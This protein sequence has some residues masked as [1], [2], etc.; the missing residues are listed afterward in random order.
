[1]DRVRERLRSTLP[2]LLLLGLAFAFIAGCV[3]ESRVECRKSPPFSHKRH[4]KDEEMACTDCHKYDAAAG[5]YAM[6][7]FK[8]CLQCH[9]DNEKKLHLDDFLVD[10]KPVWSHVTEI[11]GDVKFSHKPHAEAKVE[12]ASCHKGIE[13][14]KG[15]SSLLRVDMRE[16]IDCHAKQK[17]GQAL[18]NCAFC[19]TEIGK[20]WKP[21]GHTRN[22]MELH[23]R[24]AANVTKGSSDDCMLCHNQASCT[25]CHRVEMPKN[26]NNFWRERGHG[27]E[28][29]LDREACKT[30]HTEDSCVRCHKETAPQS[31]KGNWDNR[32]CI[33]CHTPLK[34][35]GCVACHKNTASHAA[36][37]PHLPSNAIH[38]QATADDCRNC[39]HP[40]R[41]LP[42]PDNGENCLDCHKR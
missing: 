2:L 30:C 26:H 18:N 13:S 4:V 16:C 20:N 9:Q 19:H 21:A 27:V 6:P 33:V 25:S 37:A 41:L 1:M 40:G 3:G 39:H 23:G 42:H 24:T 34:D 36:L 35:E 28:A 22:W 38:Q 14:S 7:E 32:H 29:S 31:H 12:C 10:G 15:V 5:R 11:P 17:V 8:R